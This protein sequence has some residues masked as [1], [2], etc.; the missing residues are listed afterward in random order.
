MSMLWQ[1]KHFGEGFIK[2]YETFKGSIN[3]DKYQ[4]IILYQFDNVFKTIEK[5]LK[6]DH[7]NMSFLN[8][9]VQSLRDDYPYF[10][11][12][13]PDILKMSLRGKI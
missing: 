2:A 11:F 7:P 8:Y 3:A 5:E 12:Y 6:A 13:H 1:K 10:N 9:Q 4:N